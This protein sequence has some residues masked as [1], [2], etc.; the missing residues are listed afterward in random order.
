[1]KVSFRV[2]FQ[3]IMIVF[4]I[5]ILFI[6]WNFFVLVSS[7][8][9]NANREYSDSIV[10]NVSYEI[11]SKI[12]QLDRLANIVSQNRNIQTYIVANDEREKKLAYSSVFNEIWKVIKYTDNNMYVMV[13]DNEGKMSKVINTLD[14]IDSGLVDKFFSEYHQ[15]LLLNN[16]RIYADGDSIVVCQF[17]SIDMYN[18]SVVGLDEIGTVGIVSKINIVELKNSINMTD[19]VLLEIISN[20]TD[21]R[22]KI[23][24]PKK[25]SDK[26]NV[27]T[28]KIKNTQWSIRCATPR[29]R[30]P[31]IYS[32]M[33]NLIIV[34]I[35]ICVIF[36][37]ILTGVFQRLFAQPLKKVFKYLDAYCFEARKKRLESVGTSE[38][39]TLL[40][41]TNNM[42]DI[43]EKNTRQIISTQ[44]MLYEKE[45]E[46]KNTLLY[47][48][49]L[50]IQPHFLYNTLGCI[51]GF[52]IDYGADEI[53]NITGAL[54]DIFRYS[55]E[56]A[57]IA[58]L[59]DEIKYTQRYL[60]IQK[61]RY[62]TRFDIRIDIDDNLLS[63]SVPKMILQPV[64]ENAFKHGILPIKKKGIISI[65]AVR[66]NDRIIITVKDNGAGMTEEKLS[67][68]KKMVASST[69]LGY[70]GN[71][72]GLT[73]VCRRI[74]LRYGNDFK[75]FIKSDL[76]KGTCVKLVL[77]FEEAAESKNL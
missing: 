12:E 55:M 8:I 56:N 27:N 52:A 76:H 47:M 46:E 21:E 45:I 14:D 7:I 36:L 16:V 61:M 25:M 43:I 10:K 49:Q 40:H 70:S 59:G 68:L 2:I 3:S 15:G 23:F 39:D 35:F 26:M 20:K 73:N 19:D 30:I 50:Q 28:A 9:E 41:H 75:I 17:K 5:I 6:Q 54:A 71:N 65:C 11:T 29:E 72:I 57:D 69:D 38:L 18:F 74:M 60:E 53:L 33:R 62:P 51:N 24:S 1:M 32:G 37:L 22:F 77:P 31:N 42:L 66:E 4:F 13:W 63:V 67:E 64:V 44:E 58:T 48:Y 34:T